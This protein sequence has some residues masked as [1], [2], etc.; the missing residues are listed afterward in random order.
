MPPHTWEVDSSVYRSTSGHRGVHQVGVLQPEPSSQ[1]AWVRP[2]ES[3]PPA[4]G[5]PSGL[6]HHC[7]EVSQIG[8]GLPAAE[9]AQAVCAE[10]PEGRQ[11]NRKRSVRNRVLHVSGLLHTQIWRFGSYFDPFQTFKGQGFSIT[12]MTKFYTDLVFFCYRESKDGVKI[13]L[14]TSLC[15]WDH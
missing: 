2:A 1:R 14:P 10:V 11:Q 8:Q 7:T 6:T 15:V 12:F 4:V 3:H 5:Q 13:F 9:E